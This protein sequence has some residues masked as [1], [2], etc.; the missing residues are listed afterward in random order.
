MAII[1][2]LVNSG[3]SDEAIIDLLM[4]KRRREREKMKEKH[5][6]AYKPKITETKVKTLASED[7]NFEL[8][9]AVNDDIITEN[10]N[11]GADN[12]NTDNDISID[13]LKTAVSEMADTVLYRIGQLCVST[14]LDTKSAIQII[15]QHLD[16]KQAQSLEKFTDK[17][18]VLIAGQEKLESE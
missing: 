14:K 8:R 4:E 2:D 13:A 7:A 1:D 3:L 10:I 9:Q 18:D 16:A 17:I 6:V 5:K 15:C 11:N 12:N